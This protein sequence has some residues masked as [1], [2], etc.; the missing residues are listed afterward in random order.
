MVKIDFLLFSQGRSCKT[1]ISIFKH[2]FLSSHEAKIT[3]IK[4]TC[5]KGQFWPP[6]EPKTE[7]CFSPISLK[8]FIRGMVQV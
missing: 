3:Q 6:L 1:A 4:G 7:S 2:I 8:W 5:I